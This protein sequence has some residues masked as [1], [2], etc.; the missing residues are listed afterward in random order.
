MS[1]KIFCSLPWYTMQI[2]FNKQYGPCCHI[3]Y[4]CEKIPENKEEVLNLFNSE[5]MQ[6]LRK[7]LLTGKV[8]GTPCQSCYDRN[9]NTDHDIFG[10]LPDLPRYSINKGERFDKLYEQANNHYKNDDL[11]VSVPPLELYVYTNERC[12]FDCPMCPQHF[13]KKDFPV[14]KIKNTINNIGWGKIDRF[15][16]V[17]GE[18]F[19]TKDALSLLD[20]VSETDTK[21]TCI[22]ITT[23]GS[24]L[25]KYFDKLEK[26]ENLFMTISIEGTYD[27]YEKVRKNG[28]WEKLIENLFKL[29][30]LKI[31]KPNWRLNFN[32]V[33]MLSTLSHML[34]IL[35]LAE[36]IGAT[37]M[38]YPLGGYAEENIFSNEML[39]KNKEFNRKINE[40]IE[41]AEKVNAYKALDS[42]QKIKQHFLRGRKEINLI[43]KQIEKINKQLKGEPVIVYGAG[44]HTQKLF[45]LTD[46]EFFNIKAY[47]DS[48][49]KKW[50]TEFLGKKIISPD[51][52]GA[53]ENVLISSKAFEMEIKQ[54]LASN[55]LNRIYTIYDN[56]E[57]ETDKWQ[58][59]KAHDEHKKF[60]NMFQFKVGGITCEA[61][62]AS[63]RGKTCNFHPRKENLKEKNA[64]Y[65]Y[66]LQG[67]L[68]EKPFIS[69]KMRITTF[70]SCF[71]DYVSVYLRNQG[72]NIGDK[73]THHY[74]SHIIKFSDGIVN[75]FALLQQFQWVYEN[76]NFSQNLWYGG[77]GEFAEVNEKIR[78]TTKEIFEKTDVFIIT[79]GLSE[80]W[81]NKLTGEIM[82]R[83]V[84]KEMFDEKIHG[85]RMA[86]FTENY[87]NLEKIYNIIRK[88]RGNIPIIFTLSPVPLVATFRPVSCLSAN[89]V[90]KAL[91]RASVD[92]F[93]RN[94]ETDEKLFYFPSYEIVKDF[95]S[96]PYQKD[97]RHVKEEVVETIM[98]AFGEGFLVE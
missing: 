50:N 85:F 93:Y 24:L 19:L 88:Y 83:A 77:K 38:F 70:G 10:M 78:K 84:P 55:G 71:A 82:W 46:L 57:E 31:K 43:S 94:F 7:I 12:N 73:D 67:W 86:T 13:D 14:E 96:N 92:E 80:V 29:K 37:V 32:S 27:V 89:S 9:F 79:L 58:D 25:H 87:H 22:Y 54:Q 61:E 52:I 72:Y 23:N 18:T 39:I 15:G 76:K 66:V 90:S 98:D 16:Y 26:I 8:E 95:I 42:L 34:D 49:E 20:F 62:G 36:L 40:V 59:A 69:K 44:E 11:T 48:D 41:Y 3:K 60:L 47:S 65:K 4:N 5:E 91:L 51:S 45:K 56:L 75:T 21:G 81:Y 1:K 97:N 33:V 63:Y 6:K 30:K 28:S 17:G 74:N 2:H 64:L 35:K 68:P 53:T